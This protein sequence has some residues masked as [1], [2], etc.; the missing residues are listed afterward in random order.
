MNLGI[1]LSKCE[2]VVGTAIDL[3]ALA[4]EYGHVQSVKIFDSFYYEKD[5]DFLLNEVSTHK[6]DSLVL[7][8]DSPMMYRKTRNGD[9]ILKSLSKKG[10]NTNRIIMV[11]LKNMVSMPHE[12]SQAELQLKAKLLIDVGIEKVRYSGKVK[13]VEVAPRKAVA[14]IGASISSIAVSQHFLDEGYKVFLIH[15]GEEIDLRADDSAHIYPTFVYVL[16][17]PRF[18]VINRAVVNDLYGF[19]GDYTLE[20]SSNANSQDRSQNISVGA[21]VLAL[22]N[23]RK[24]I[25][26]YQSVFRLDVNENGFLSPLDETSARS[27][28]LDRGIFVVDYIKSDQNNISRKLVSADAAASMVINL[29][30]RKEIFHRIMVSQVNTRLC[31]G[32]GACV[33]TCIFKA[34][35]LQEDPAI[36]VIDPERC[37]GCGNCVT[38]CPADA[39]DLV[40]YPSSYL[41]KA[42][43][44]LSKFSSD[45]NDPKMLVMACDGCGYRC[46][47][48]AGAAGYTWPVS[49]MPLKLVCGGQIDTQLIMH[50]FVK[51]FDYVVLMVCAEGSCHNAIG[52]VELER[53]V[54][55]FREI[56]ASRGIDHKRMHIIAASRNSTECVERISRIYNRQPSSSS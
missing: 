28:T 43:D 20:I 42:V 11:N 48:D 22:E 4:D 54:N 49:V 3:E 7:A 46:L 38:A 45:N 36:S 37:R 30:N 47:D 44:I 24:L 19:P 29:L 50:A 27:Q 18:R 31:S 8:G 32:C 23:N 12:A 16:R 51:G 40:A 39:R 41:F 15:E 34:V 33:K 35:S 6:L 53:R 21:A 56:L 9:Y 2:G 14:V 10:I 1:F 26:E 13:M 52:N 5:F 55:L 25:K 17:H